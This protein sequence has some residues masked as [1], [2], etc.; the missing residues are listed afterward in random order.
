MKF[1]VNTRA[2]EK[3]ESQNVTEKFVQPS[4]P[5]LDGY[6]D[7]WSMTMENFLRS[8]EMWSLVDEGIPVPATGTAAASEAQRKLVEEAK[9]KDLKVKNFLFQ[10]ISRE[11]LETI[12]D[13]GTSR[14]IWNSMKQKYHGSTKVKRAQL[15]ALRKEFELLAM[16][17]GEKVDSFLG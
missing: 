4:I 13:K 9:L 12:L 7:Y 11:I 6:Y 3:C 16:K 2:C 17:E 10:A 1:R 15:Q 14:A 5:K 8:K